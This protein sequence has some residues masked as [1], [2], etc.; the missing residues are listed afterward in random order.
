[1]ITKILLFLLI[2]TCFAWDKIVPELRNE[3]KQRDKLD[4]MIIMKVQVDFNELKDHN[5]LYL[6]QLDWIQRGRLVLSEL[7]KTAKISQS[8]LISYLEK[9][10]LEYKSFYVSNNIAVWNVPRDVLIEIA[11]RDDISEIQSNGPLDIQLEPRGKPADPPTEDEWNV[12]WINATHLYKLGFTGEGMVVANSDTGVDFTH[13]ALF[14]NYRGN[15]GNGKIDH[16]YNWY[17]G[18]RHGTCPKECPCPSDVP[19][20]VYGHGTHTIGTAAGTKGIGVAKGAKWIAC[21]SIQ[22]SS[23]TADSF[24]SCL[25]FFLAPHDLKGQN[26]DPDL[27]PVTTGH[28]YGCR[29]G[30]ETCRW[31]AWINAIEALNAAGVMV[32]ASAGN[33]GPSC[34][35]VYGPPG[36]LESVLT[37]GALGVKTDKIADFSSRGVVTNDGSN[38]QKP[39]LCAPGEDVKS[40]VPGGDY[41][42]MSGTSMSCPAVSGAIALLWSAVPELAR[43]IKLTQEI[44]YQTAHHQKTDECSGN[45][46]IPNN[47]YGYGTVNIGNAFEMARK[48]FRN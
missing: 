36:M 26:P 48:L 19:C 25:Q 39:N 27:R 12:Q 34:K 40:A 7:M 10:G 32:V 3:M 22:G 30:N 18:C 13:P 5:G 17:D 42:F 9:K 41:E 38:R 24:L 1:M 6:Y 28:S 2:A 44:L 4:I 47:V 45:Q 29:T 14:P 11:K 23:T 15:L 31:N 35:S 33:M 20:D 16:N 37:V 46:K 43:D 21:R 8:P